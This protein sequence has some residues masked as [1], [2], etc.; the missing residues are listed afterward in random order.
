[1][2]NRNLE[3]LV[4]DPATAPAIIPHIPVACIAV[5]ES[6]MRTPEDI[7]PAAA[8]GSDAI[9]VGSAIS[10]SSDPAADVRGLAAIPRSRSARVPHGV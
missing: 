3:T 5:A 4:I 2:N 7:G 6:G 1:V 10:A 8:A 9:L